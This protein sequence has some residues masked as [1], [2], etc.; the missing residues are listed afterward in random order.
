MLDHHIQRTIVYR[1]AFSEGLRFSELKPDTLENKLFDYH[2]KKVVAAGYVVKA[3]DGLY[4]L[5]PEGRRLGIRAL[6]KQQALADHAESVLFLIIRRASDGAWLFYKRSTH[7]MLGYSGFMHA[8]PNARENVSLSA[9]KA[10]LEKTGL[11]GSFKALGGGYSRIFDAAGELQSFTN[12]TLVV[13][14]NTTGELSGEDT[15][16]DYRWELSP[17]FTSTLLFPS[18]A[19]LYELYQAGQPFF[20]ERSFTV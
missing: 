13:C 11:S 17:D 20:V 1:L 7:P 12:F 18:T 6:D 19:M 3:T 2:L 9:Q 15:F 5:S 14:E 10:C 16:A 4:T 8:T